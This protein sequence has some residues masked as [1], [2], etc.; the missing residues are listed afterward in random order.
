MKAQA[1]INSETAISKLNALKN[2]AIKEGSE[3]EQ[4][5]WLRL[6]E[7]QGIIVLLDDMQNSLTAA[8]PAIQKTNN[9]EARTQ[10]LLLQG[11]LA[12][13]NGALTDAKKFLNAA[14]VQAQRSALKHLEL[15]ARVELAYTYTLEDNFQQA[16]KTNHLAHLEARNNND[17][18]ITALAEDIYGAI[19]GYMGQYEE[20]IDYY[21][22]A[23]AGYQ[24]LGYH[25]YTS[26]AIFGIATSHRYWGKYE[27]ALKYFRQHQQLLAHTKNEGSKF[28]DYYGIATTL[29]AMDDCQQALPAIDKALTTQG[30][31]DYKAEL[32]KIQAKC[33]IKQEQLGKAEQALT[34]AETI[35]EQL[36][37]LK[38]TNWQIETL[39]IAANLAKENNNYPKAFELLTTYNE[40]KSRIDSA[41]Y[42]D[43]IIAYKST[44]ESQQKDLEIKL[45]TENAKIQQLTADNQIRTNKLQKLLLLGL[46]ITVVIILIFAY[47]LH[48]N[49]KR[50]SE[51]SIRDE[52]TGLYN[53]RYIFDYLNNILCGNKEEKQFSIIIADIDNFKQIND[54]YGHPAGDS[55]IK[56]IAKL[57]VD[58]LRMTD[59]VGRIGGE[60][61]LFILPRI[62]PQ[63]CED[64]VK[65]LLHTVREKQFTLPNGETI[66]VTISM[67]IC[68]N[69]ADISDAKTIFHKADEALYISKK[70][71][72]DQINSVENVAG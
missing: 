58:T 61:F 68:H 54:N 3:A 50:I 66:K 72:K 5:Y 65:R 70:S 21:Q 48:K 37:D 60:E 7:A 69:N 27:Q 18:F 23:L 4:W 1:Y 34:A 44:L 22:Q 57:S 28:Y 17:I 24:K 41:T 30:P 59:I 29:A 32:Y 26:S 49:L 11:V 43:K 67:G 64:I 25:Q 9:S 40:K 12:Q 2:K 56:A 46:S 10:L 39:L 51:L 16:L 63:Q 15:H 47:T 36:P 6:A 14:I 55:V 19:Y 53:R 33:F 20:S 35:F 52:L 38:D 13:N 62:P 31:I 71:G 45:L 42:S 8:K